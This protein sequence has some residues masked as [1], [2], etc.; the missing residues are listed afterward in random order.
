MSESLPED[1]LAVER[2]KKS[3]RLATASL[4][5]LA[6]LAR[7]VRIKPTKSVTVAAVG[8]SGLMVVNPT[9]FASV[10]LADA[11]FVLA[12]ELLHLAL[13]THGR[14]GDAMPLIVNFAH[15]YVINDMLMEELERD[16]PLNGLR[17]EG[18]RHRS[19]EELVVQLSQ[20]ATGGRGL[21]CWG[22]PPR[23]KKRPPPQGTPR[24]PISHALEDAGLV[25]PPP[26]PPLPPPIPDG[27][28][29]DLL[30]DL[31]E[32]LLEQ[33]IPRQLRETLREAVRREAVKAASLSGLRDRMQQAN[34][35]APFA[36]PQR[37]AAMMEALRAAYSTPWELAM[38]RWLDA[39]GPGERTY[40]RPSRRAGSRTDVVLPGRRR[41][42]WTLHVLLDT[43][44]SMADIIPKV[45]GAISWF[46]E[47]SGVA[48][49]HV[50][51]CDIEVTDDRWIEPI[52]LHEYRVAGFGSSDMGPGMYHLALDTDVEAA[53]VITD[54]YI[55]YPANPLPYSVL[56][57]LAG[58]YNQYDTS[59]SPPYGQ[60]VHM[61]FD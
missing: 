13:D 26:P 44:G 1:L 23:G 45:L 15:D 28:Q 5:H 47:A 7:L 33:E 51:Q 34:Q 24:S 36:Q 12:H 61:H 14:Q 55:D 58:S 3:L 9:V 21:S 42:G 56:W 27:P 48:Q 4:P 50:V 8:R 59:F 41:E 19:L 35:E 18:A 22:V 46:C 40:A 60:V 6:G 29:G 17:L 30:P 31:D 53:L 11:A 37:G 39:V 38:Q 43:S 52:D 10:P 49:V 20:S 2:A 16:P 32:E 25:E 57:C 54:G